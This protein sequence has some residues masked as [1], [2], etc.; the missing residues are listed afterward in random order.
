MN[1]SESKATAEV[2]Q[3]ADSVLLKVGGTWRLTETLPHLDEVLPREPAGRQLKVIPVDL[4]EWDSSLP[5][6]LLRVR[7][8]CR[9][10]NTE[11]RLDALPNAL[12]RLFL[13]IAESEEQA[14][15]GNSI[16]PRA[17]SLLRSIRKILSNWSDSIRFIG[18]C[19]TGTIEVP[20]DPRHFSWRDFFVEMVEA[21]PKAMPIIGL[22]S[23]LIGVTFAF[24]TATQLR[25]FGA[26]I[27]VIDGV[28]VA[29]VRQIGPIIAAVVLA[30]R[31]GAA[32][33]AHIANMKLG[34]EIDALEM[35]GVS[36]ITFLVLPRLAALFLM[37]PLIT[38]YSDFLGILGGLIVTVS[39]INIPGIEFWDKLKTAVSLTDVNI[40]IVKGL[41]FGLLVGLSGTLHGLQSERSSLGVGHAVTAAV[42]VGITAIIIANAL[43]SPILNNL[44]F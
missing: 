4:V 10:R 32:F 12:T 43:F 37:M 34:G 19:A 22:L 36:P 31:T 38:L 27:Y 6:F 39:M 13:L 25:Q 11:L 15:A 8:W 3:S 35:L 42:V 21:G 26:Q 5:I 33:A 9:E 40:G 1:G 17:H 28:G 29:V 44:G 23:F 18:E 30:G 20:T 41:V 24:E 16:E 14:P 7:S 2:E